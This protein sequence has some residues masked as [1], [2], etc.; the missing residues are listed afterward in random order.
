M[1]FLSSTHKIFN[2]FSAAADEALENFVSKSVVTMGIV[3]NKYYFK[4]KKLIT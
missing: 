1:Y 4:Y 2:R 3:M